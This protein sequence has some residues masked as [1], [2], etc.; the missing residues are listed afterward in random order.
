VNILKPIPK[1]NAKLEELVSSNK[2]YIFG[3]PL[4]KNTSGCTWCTYN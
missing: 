3:I 2:S 1:L 4:C